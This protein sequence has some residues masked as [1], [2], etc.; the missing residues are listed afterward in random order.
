MCGPVGMMSPVECVA[1]HWWYNFCGVFVV[2]LREICT[3]T[4]THIRNCLP[5]CID[6]YNHQVQH[7]V[8][9]G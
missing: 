4:H 1:P 5:C 3:H 9:N 7:N 8:G 2:P 6:G